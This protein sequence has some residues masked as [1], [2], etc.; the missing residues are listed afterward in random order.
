MNVCISESCMTLYEPL[1]LRYRICAQSLTS[2]GQV[3]FSIQVNI[4]TTY[5]ME[6]I[7]VFDLYGP[8]QAPGFAL[9]STSPGHNATIILPFNIVDFDAPSFTY[10][11][12]AMNY[13]V[14][15]HLGIF[16][17]KMEAALEA[18]KRCNAHCRRSFDLLY[19]EGLC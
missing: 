19:Q 1:T 2:V 12:Q 7:G 11:L 18:S 13:Q 17:K 5:L 9:R 15:L 14:R 6:R 16:H 10:T 3:T 4:Q 8:L